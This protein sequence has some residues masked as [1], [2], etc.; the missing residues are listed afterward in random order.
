MCT[1]SASAKSPEYPVSHMNKAHFNK[2]HAL[3]FVYNTNT[4]V[5]DNPATK[6]WSDL[7]RE[8]VTDE[9]EFQVEAKRIGS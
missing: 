7:A 4:G 8:K 2:G 9:P 3:Y 1:G 5:A 6:L